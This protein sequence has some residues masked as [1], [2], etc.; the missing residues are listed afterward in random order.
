MKGDQTRR[1]PSTDQ[2]IDG[3]AGLCSCIIR[4]SPKHLQVLGLMEKNQE[5][6][7]E[8]EA[9]EERLRHETRRAEKRRLSAANRAELEVTVRSLICC[10]FCVSI[11]V[12]AFSR[13]MILSEK[14]SCLCVQGVRVFRLR[15]LSQGKSS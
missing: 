11:V 8:A 12:P 9:F 4:V 15:S 3:T 5:L 10:F 1:S 14:S 6:T 13:V 2:V 7:E